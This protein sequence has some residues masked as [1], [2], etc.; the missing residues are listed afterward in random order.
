MD[1]ARRADN[2]R[3]GLRGAGRTVV[4]WNERGGLQPEA[5]DTDLLG[6]GR[7]MKDRAVL[8]QFVGK[9]HILPIEKQASEFL[10][11]L[12]LGGGLAVI[13]ELA[14]VAE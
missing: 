3:R 2:R 11:L 1:A 9:E 14:L 8:M 4:H 13:D 5:A 10:D 6:I 12:V 7:S